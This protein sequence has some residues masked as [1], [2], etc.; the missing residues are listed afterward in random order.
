MS[1][2]VVFPPKNK[3]DFIS[4]QLKQ[5]WVTLHWLVPSNEKLYVVEPAIR[6]CFYCS[7]L[8]LLILQILKQLPRSTE[9]HLNNLNIPVVSSH[10]CKPAVLPATT[11]ISVTV[12]SCSCDW[13]WFSSSPQDRPDCCGGKLGLQCS[14]A[15]PHG[16]GETRHISIW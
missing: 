7:S 14:G 8:S 4:Q 11:N 3:H 10:Q 5:K 12:R 13:K 2:D 15:A 16:G 1:G 6:I 9:P